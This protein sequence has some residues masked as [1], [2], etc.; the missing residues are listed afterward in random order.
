MFPAHDIVDIIML[1]TQTCLFILILA[2][3]DDIEQ[4][5]G[6]IFVSTL[7]ISFL[8]L[9]GFNYFTLL[10]KIFYPISFGKH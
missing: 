1:H 10:H 5:R 6:Q 8:Y 9:K 3:F 4:R 2:Q 7:L